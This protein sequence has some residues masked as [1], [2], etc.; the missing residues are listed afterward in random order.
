MHSGGGV[1]AAGGCGSADMKR[2]SQ[3][4]CGWVFQPSFPPPPPLLVGKGEA[5]G[6]R[7]PACAVAPSSHTLLVICVQFID[8]PVSLIH[9]MR[10]LF[11]ALG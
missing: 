10:Q 7:S 8:M 3:D 4:D 9:L 1:G 5:T 6:V 2:T 11:P